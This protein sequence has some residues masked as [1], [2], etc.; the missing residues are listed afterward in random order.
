MTKKYFLIIFFVIFSS[1]L[2]S[3]LFLHENK[4]TPADGIRLP[5]DN[6]VRLISDSEKPGVIEDLSNSQYITS[7]RQPVKNE[8]ISQVFLD[9]MLLLEETPRL[10]KNSMLADAAIEKSFLFADV[11][12]NQLTPI[13][14]L[15]GSGSPILYGNI[16]EAEPLDLDG[17]PVRWQLS[18]SFLA[19]LSPP[20]QWLIL[21][22][23]PP[24]KRDTAR[25]SHPRS[26]KSYRDL[27]ENFARRFNLNVALVMAIIHSESNFSPNLVSHKSAMGLMQ[28]LPS[29]A[30]DEVHRFLYGKRGQIGFEDLSN[31]EL[32]IRYGTA[33]LHILSN[34]YFFAVKNWEV[35]EACIIAAYNLG[36]NRFIK[37]YGANPE[38]AA[39]IINQMTP[40]E[41]FADLQNRLPTRETRNYVQKVREMK[42]HYTSLN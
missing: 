5:A 16:R 28:L 8:S 7:L 25:I 30:S 27:V 6:S 9:A 13:L 22:N 39:E 36:P 38:K 37:L 24:P 12:Q 20:R 32:N 31:P 10:I 29:T 40:E 17:K 4:S 33:Y 21:K 19:G 23:E 11:P 1:F 15:D 42:N 34:R 26:A 2:G 35:K 18:S 3:Y 14:P 41:F